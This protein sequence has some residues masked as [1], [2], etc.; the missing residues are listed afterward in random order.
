M[1]RKFPQPWWDDPGAG[2]LV[3]CS[4]FQPSVTRIPSRTYT[5]VPFCQPPLKVMRC[6]YSRNHEA[7]CTRFPASGTGRE[8]IFSFIRSF[9]RS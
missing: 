3:S 7:P 6:F 4:G 9:V 1:I 2:R 5:R 8:I